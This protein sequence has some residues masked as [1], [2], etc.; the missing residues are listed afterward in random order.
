[1]TDAQRQEIA[2]CLRDID[3]ARAALEQQANAENRQIVRGL[4]D[5]ADHIFD[6]LNGLEE[7][8]E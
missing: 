1:M 5:A 3:E 2:A 8:S 7:T 4:R 6:L